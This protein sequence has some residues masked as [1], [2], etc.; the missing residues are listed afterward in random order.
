MKRQRRTKR[1]GSVK[2]LSPVPLAHKV[3][4]SVREFGVDTQHFRGEL[5]RN[6]RDL[7]RAASALPR[8]TFSREKILDALIKLSEVEGTLRQIVVQARDASSDLESL[9]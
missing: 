7:N 3:G 8:G 5:I 9:R 4:T 6:M 1:R 2:V